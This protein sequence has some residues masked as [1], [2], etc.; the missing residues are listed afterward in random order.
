MPVW[1]EKFLPILIL[2][3]VVSVV[4]GRLP[5]VDHG[6]SPAFLRRRLWNWLPLGLSYAFLYMGRYNLAVAKNALGDLMTIEDFSNIKAV[7]TYVYG[8]SFLLNGPLTDRL[9]GRKTMLICIAGT[10]AMNLGM[11]AYLASGPEG[12]I[13]GVFSLLYGVNMY[14]QSFGAASIVK[15]NAHWFGLKERGTFGGIFGILISLGIY[16][17]YDWGK[18]IVEAL[19]TQWVFFIPAIILVF[20]WFIDYFLVYDSP[21]DVGLSDIDTQDA[22]WD[23]GPQKQGVM[24]IAKMM[25]TNPVIIIIGLVELCSGFLRAALMDYYIIFA[26]ETGIYSSFVPSNW[27]MLQCAAGIL[28]G[29]IAGTISDR[30]FHSRRG[31]V[32][33][34]LY[35]VVLVSAIGMVFSLSSPLLGAIVVLMMLS[36]IGVHGMLSGT[37]SMDFG[38]KKNVG[39]AVGIIDGLVY[40]GQGTQAVI[41][42]QL[43]PSGPEKAVAQNWVAWPVAL[44]VAALVG[45]LLALRLWNARPTK[46]GAATH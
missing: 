40:L 20:F 29:V 5:K 16:F 42:G 27:G 39:I 8:I 45:T 6:H 32:S 21:A 1:L 24:Q 44:A 23:D 4:L 35:G 33:A 43:L 41:L 13:T 14:F 10:V 38:G 9:G 12:N 36:I 11:G 15:V 22:S 31:P 18:M 2:L 25:L 46:G 37:A 34:V 17:A 7:G 3:A 30:L 19:P 28:G 26:K